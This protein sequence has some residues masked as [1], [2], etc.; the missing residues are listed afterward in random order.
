MSINQ[1]IICYYCYYY[2]YAAVFLQ[3]LMNEIVIF[4]LYSIST[5]SFEIFQIKISLMFF[6]IAIFHTNVTTIRVQR[7]VAYILTLCTAYRSDAGSP[8]RNKNTVVS[9]LC[10]LLSLPVC[11]A[12]GACVPLFN[13]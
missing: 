10:R 9:L 11:P 2:Y 13:Y 5:T 7:H 6:Y 1:V 8:A 4:L 12:R 3:I